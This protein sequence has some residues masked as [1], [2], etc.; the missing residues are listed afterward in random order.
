MVVQ[1]E[2]EK[3]HQVNERDFQIREDFLV[4]EAGIELLLAEEEGEDGDS[5]SVFLGEGK[6]ASLNIENRMYVPAI[7]MRE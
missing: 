6:T 1:R 4:E 5:K 7:T 2:D 3:L